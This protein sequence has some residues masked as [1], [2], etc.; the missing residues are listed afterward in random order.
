MDSVDQNSIRLNVLYRTQ[1]LPFLFLYFWTLRGRHRTGNF[2]ATP[3]YNFP[4]KKLKL[5]LGFYNDG[6]VII[7]SSN[8]PLVQNQLAEMSKFQYYRRKAWDWT[9]VTAKTVF[10]FFLHQSYRLSLAGL[11]F[12]GFNF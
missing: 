10:N 11:Y 12:A 9:K 1:S 4:A 7:S 6:K 2:L 3:K 5:F 8:A